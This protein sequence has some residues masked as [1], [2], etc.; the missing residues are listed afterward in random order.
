MKPLK[1]LAQS[2]AKDLSPRPPLFA[3]LIVGYACAYKERGSR[4]CLRDER[5]GHLDGFGV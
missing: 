2:R 5:K 3:S 1:P 4:A